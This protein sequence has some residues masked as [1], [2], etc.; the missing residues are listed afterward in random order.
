MKKWLEI[1]YE[2]GEFVYLKTDRDQFE[3]MVTGY[4]V[5]QNGITYEL[6]LGSTTSWHYDFEISAEKDIKVPRFQE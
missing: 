4:C 5:R 3:R 2:P 6:S 1:S